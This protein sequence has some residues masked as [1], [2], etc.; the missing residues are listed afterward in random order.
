M[1]GFGS[2]GGLVNY[3]TKSRPTKRC[4]ASS[5]ATSQG[6][7]R[8]HVDLGGRVGE[9]GAFGYR[10]NAT[11]EEGNTYNG[12]S[13][14]RD[15]VSLALDARLSDRLTWD[16]QSIYQDRKAIGQEPTI[17]A[18]TMAGSELPSPVRKRQ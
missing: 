12:G 4:A 17:Y 14:Y 7:L 13:L 3:V 18:G 5:W 1:Y 10:L 16:F 11:H 15:S 8:E 6:M 2:P 9:S